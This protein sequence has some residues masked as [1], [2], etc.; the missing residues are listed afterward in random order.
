VAVCHQRHFHIEVRT[1]PGSYVTSHKL[2]NSDWG[3]K[4][5]RLWEIQKARKLALLSELVINNLVIINY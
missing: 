3:V 1:V 2:R 5:S 4:E